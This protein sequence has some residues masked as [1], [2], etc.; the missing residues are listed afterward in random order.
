MTVE[1]VVG[2]GGIV[3]GMTD[4]GGATPVPEEPVPA[5]GVVE[6]D[7]EPGV[8]P[9]EDPVEAPEELPGEA[10]MADGG[11]FPVE[12]VS[13]EAVAAPPPRR[14]RA[15]RATQGVRRRAAGWLGIGW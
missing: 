12:A 8:A 5:L 4:P 3:G 9:E 7:P 15:A 11:G 2:P 14:T 6:D 13:A 1:V 10:L